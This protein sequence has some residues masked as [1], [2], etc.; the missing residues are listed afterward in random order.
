M[1]KRFLQEERERAE[2]EEVFYMRKQ[3]KQRKQRNQRKQRG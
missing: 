2:S 1:R 3:R